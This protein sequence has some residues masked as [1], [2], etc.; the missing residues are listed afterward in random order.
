MI[1]V[2]VSDVLCVDLVAF[3]DNVCIVTI[4]VDFLLIAG[5][6]LISLIFNL[7]YL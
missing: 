6:Y 1:I 2:A 7:V 4:S 5:S 3:Q